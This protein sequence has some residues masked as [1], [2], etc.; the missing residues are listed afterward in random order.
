MVDDVVWVRV[1]NPTLEEKK[2]DKNARIGC[3]KNIEKFQEYNKIALTIM[4]NI[5][6]DLISR[7]I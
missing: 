6:M 7:N 5:G 3:A 2:V 4:E 1:L